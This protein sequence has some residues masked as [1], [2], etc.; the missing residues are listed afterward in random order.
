MRTGFNAL[1]YFEARNMLSCA[2]RILKVM[3]CASPARPDIPEGIDNSSSIFKQPTR[4]RDFW[5]WDDIHKGTD[6]LLWEN[7]F[8]LC[9]FAPE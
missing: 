3:V 4:I 9:P 5:P 1:E 2:V 8:L 6:D 7:V